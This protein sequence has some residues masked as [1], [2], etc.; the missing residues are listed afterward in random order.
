MLNSTSQIRFCKSRDGTTIAFSVTGTGP[1][2]LWL[3]LHYSDND[4][5]SPGPA[6]KHWMDALSKFFTVIT[7]DMRGCGLSERQPCSMTLD[8]WVADIEAVVDAA[9]LGRFA[10]MTVCTGSYAAIEYAARHAERLSHLVIYGGSVRGRLRRELST[11]QREDALSALQV[12]ESG[13][14]GRSEFAATFRQVFT[15][16]FLPD[17]TPEQLAAIDAILNERMTGAIAA[18]S[19]REF[20]QLDLS[21][22][23]QS[24][25]VPTL[26]LHALHDILYPLSE[27]QKLAALIPAAR[28]LP[29]ASNN[30]MVLEGES[31]WPLVRQTVLAFLDA[32]QDTDTGKAAVNLTTRQCEVLR[33]VANGKAD[34]EIA[35]VLSLSPRTIE[36]HVAGALKAMGCKTRAEAV[37]HAMQRGLLLPE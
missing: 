14:D 5:I 17:A 19:V 10:M 13:L 12:Y 7:F 35:R 34:K 36:M 22:R 28:F 29:V 24:I 11:A 18:Q 2:L 6:S 23:A 33:H 21:V 26:V 15:V 30:N 31:A 9:G 4:L 25:R 3:T 8:D 37:H 32:R 16:Q 20:Y 27:G 1:P